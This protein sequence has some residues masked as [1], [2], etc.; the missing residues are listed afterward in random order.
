MITPTLVHAQATSGNIVGT[1]TDPSGAG[2]P[3]ATVTATNV[4]TGITNKSTSNASGEFRID[5]LL[6]GQYNLEGQSPGFAPFK[7]QNFTVT[8]NQTSTAKLGLSLAGTA[9][10]VEVS[11]ESAAAIDTTTIQLQQNFTLKESQDLPTATIGLGAINLSLLSPGVATSGGIG[12]GTGPSVGGQRPRNNNYTIEGVD[13]NDKSVTGPLL[14]IPNDATGE[15]TLLTNQFSPEFGH[16]TGGQFNT[17][18]ISGT[19][20]LH[21]RAYE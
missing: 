12:A 18:V 5:N 6:A 13:D 16:S 9:T 20:S 3:N 15:F 11:A 2:V 17:D 4:A 7:L 1:V 21:G 14:T 8:L 19:N 10:S